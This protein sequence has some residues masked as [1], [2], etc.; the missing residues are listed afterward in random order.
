MLLLQ[1]INNF[2]K[3]LKAQAIEETQK[4]DNKGLNILENVVS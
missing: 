3:I 4:I 2:N 1:T